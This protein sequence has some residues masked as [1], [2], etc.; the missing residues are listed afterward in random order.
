[1]ITAVGGLKFSAPH[2][3]VL[4]SSGSPLGLLDLLRSQA[5]GETLLVVLIV[6]NILWL[7]LAGIWLAISYVFAAVLLTLTII[8]IPFAKQAFKLAHYALW[9]FGRAL[10]QSSTRH[11]GISVV[12]NVLWFALAGWWLALEHVILGALLC[13]TIIGIPLG[14]GSFK[15]AG[16]ALVP[17][18][19]QIVKLEELAQPPPAAIA[20]GE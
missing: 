16:A 9:P 7:V 18:G 11:K 14:V 17:F 2:R 1:M 8:G 6:L 12:G 15:M 10:V 20:I 3:I 5:E 4:K 19:R 13:L